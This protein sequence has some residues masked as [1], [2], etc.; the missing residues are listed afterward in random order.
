M[1]PVFVT[2]VFPVILWQG[3]F[4]GEGMLFLTNE[5]GIIYLF[6][7]VEGLTHMGCYKKQNLLCLYV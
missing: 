6:F 2:F 1:T 5:C 7:A 3:I 4:Y